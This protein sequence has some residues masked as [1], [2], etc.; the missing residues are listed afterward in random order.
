MIS[1][2][3]FQHFHK[4]R[5]VKYI[6][7][8]WQH[9]YVH[10]PFIPHDSP[11]DTS[12]PPGGDQHNTIRTPCTVDSGRGGIFEHLHAFDIIGVQELDVFHH[13]AIDNEQRIRR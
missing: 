2:S 9:T 8:S 1:E 11:L 7:F 4:L 12:T 3:T 6:E 10:E 13:H 5:S